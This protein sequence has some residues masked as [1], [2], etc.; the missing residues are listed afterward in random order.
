MMQKECREKHVKELE[1]EGLPKDLHILI[2]QKKTR[3]WVDEQ[4]GPTTPHDAAQTFHSNSVGGKI[5]AGQVKETHMS[6]PAQS[7]HHNTPMRAKGSTSCM[8]GGGKQPKNVTVSAA[9]NVRE[10]LQEA[11]GNLASTPDHDVENAGHQGD[12]NGEEEQHMKINT[13]A[14][15]ARLSPSLGYHASGNEITVY[16]PQGENAREVED[17]GHPISLVWEKPH[18]SGGSKATSSRDDEGSDETYFEEIKA[19]HK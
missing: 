8:V 4:T 11:W 2:N 17:V 13:E 14:G 1:N 3:K 15:S 9:S 16:V 5:D 7:E 18:A 6:S 19:R 12:A 10:Q